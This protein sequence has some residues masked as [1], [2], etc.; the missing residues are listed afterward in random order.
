MSQPKLA[1]PKW[2]HVQPSLFAFV[3]YLA[4]II[5]VEFFNSSWRTALTFQAG[6]NTVLYRLHR[7]R[8]SQPKRPQRASFPRLSI[9]CP[10]VMVFHRNTSLEARLFQDS[11]ATDILWVGKCAEVILFFIC[12]RPLLTAWNPEG[13]LDWTCLPK[14]GQRR[15]SEL[16]SCS[17]FPR[18][19]DVTYKRVL[20]HVVF[21]SLLSSSAFLIQLSDWKSGCFSSALDVVILHKLFSRARFLLVWFCR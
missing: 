2:S 14:R 11:N 3:L 1:R 12:C 9:Y 6:R 13:I 15:L 16:R 17:P 10:E 8:S 19:L 20:T 21:Q 18:S 7:S 5:E 4:N